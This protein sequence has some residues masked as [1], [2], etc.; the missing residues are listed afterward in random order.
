MSTENI[1]KKEQAGPRRASATGSE[2]DYNPAQC[3]RAEVER[4]KATNRFTPMEVTHFYIQAAVVLDEHRRMSEALRDIIGTR[5][6]SGSHQLMKYI[7][8]RALPMGETAKTPN[9]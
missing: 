8:T 4:F 3:L 2:S 7:A 5:Y 6:N 1:D 9:S